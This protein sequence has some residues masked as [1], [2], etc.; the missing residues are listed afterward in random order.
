L[1][2]ELAAGG[3]SEG[4]RLEVSQASG[5]QVVLGSVLSGGSERP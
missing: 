2:E 3:Y 1:I 5:N 4:Q